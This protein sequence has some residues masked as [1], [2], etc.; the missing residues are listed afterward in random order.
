M[1]QYIVRH[2]PAN[3][4]IFAWISS[5][6]LVLNIFHANIPTIILGK[7]YFVLNFSCL[8]MSVVLLFLYLY[9]EK[10][11]NLDRIKFNMFDYLMISTFFIVLATSV[12]YLS[13]N[14]SYVIRYAALFLLAFFMKRDRY[15]VRVIFYTL[16]VA[17]VIHLIATLWFYMD[18]QFYYNNILPHFD[19]RQR[20]HLYAQMF[21][22]NYATGLANNFSLNGMYMAIMSIISYAFLYYKKHKIASTC[23]FSLCVL[24]LFM[25]GKRG[26]LLFAIVSFIVTYMICNKNTVLHKLGILIPIIIGMV[27][28]IYIMSFYVESINATLA[29]FFNS[30]GNKDFST[31]RFNLY[32]LAWNMFLD[33]PIFGVGWR[34]YANVISYRN[35]GDGAFRD[36]HNVYLQILAETGIFGFIVFFLLFLLSFVRTITIIQKAMKKTHVV[37]SHARM[38]LIFSVSYQIFFLGYSMTGNPLYDLSTMYVYFFCIGIVSY[39]D[40]GYK[41]ILEAPD[42]R[43]KLVSKYIRRP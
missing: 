24:A 21:K 2:R 43:V 10:K 25:T 35:Y 30:E 9:F 11:L 33:K 7:S 31:G 1:S 4:K 28:L 20:E 18:K 6:L 32:K 29:R 22:N 38:L 14:F 17:M 26:V 23:F 42:E 40:T 8:V 34:Q 3:Y 12:S 16:F 5:A 41:K 37:S 19:A 13:D 39:V 36:A 15:L 27:V